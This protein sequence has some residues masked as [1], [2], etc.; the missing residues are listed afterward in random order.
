MNLGMSTRLR[1][2]HD[3]EYRHERP[4]DQ[5]QH[6]A[7]LIPRDSAAQ[8]VLAWQI[9]IDPL[10]DGWTAPCPGNEGEAEAEAARHASR[11]A[12]GNQRLLFSHAR[13]HQ[14]L[15]VSSQFLVEQLDPPAWNAAASPPWEDV[16]ERLRYH[17]PGDVPAPAT[18]IEAVEFSL[19]SPFAAPDGQLAA[20][21]RLAFTPGLPVL[22]GGLR[23][24][25]QIHGDFLYAP[26]STH[27]GTRPAEALRL[28]RGVCQDFAQVFIAA[29]R[30]LGLSARYVSGYLLTVPPP[31]QARLIGAD[32]SHAWAE[33]WCPLQGWI[34]L[35]PTNAIA[36]GREHVL[37]AWGRDYADVAP[38]RGVIR[39]G[40][41]QALPRVAV[42]V[43]PA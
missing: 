29:C 18:L 13:V 23:L 39:G 33:L 9:S 16:A 28:R 8:R 30:A 31:G 7:H 20:Y 1:V 43:E 14:R 25:R 3:T 5:A 6:V 21:A 40:G 34:G 12:F 35:D 42:T 4:V 38:L 17:A 27:V 15:S 2:R 24:M 10:P 32:A 41:G 26:L 11:D 36:V 22:E 37:L 19:A